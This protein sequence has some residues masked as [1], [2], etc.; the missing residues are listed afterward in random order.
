MTQGKARKAAAL[1]FSM[2][3]ALLLSAC[4]KE[5]EVQKGRIGPSGLP[6]PRYVALKFDEVNA[7]AGPGEDH[8]VLW[9]YRA[10]G[11]PVQVV[12]ETRDWR[13]VCDPQGGLAWIKGRVTDGRRT[14]M[15]VENQPVAMRAQPRL[16]AK[17]DAY[18]SGQAIA[19]LDK[20]EDGWCRVK[21]GGRRGWVPEN[22]V[23]GTASKTQC[24]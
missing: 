6:V 7:R 19:S 8:K 14:V 15:R 23:W 20:C 3:T 18:L 17:T 11:L 13:R 16:E 2:V 4:Q 24:R 12:A 21:A 22:A 1:A 10:K 9:V 5:T